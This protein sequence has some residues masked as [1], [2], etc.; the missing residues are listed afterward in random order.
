MALTRRAL[1]ASSVGLLAPHHI[2]SGPATL[3]GMHRFPKR[4]EL[5]PGTL[6]ERVR[7]LQL[8]TLSGEVGSS[9]QVPLDQFYVR[10]RPPKLP[11]RWPI[12][13]TGHVHQ[14]IDLDPW[15]FEGEDQGEVLME[16]SGNRRLT[17]FGLISTNR[18]EG[19][20]LRD[21]LAEIEL[22]PEAKGL[23]VIGFG[24]QGVEV[25]RS[26]IFPLE[27][28][29]QAFLATHLAGEALPLLHGAPAR[30][31]VP[32]WYGCCAIKWVRE[33]R[34]VG[35]DARPS[36]HM[37]AYASRVHQEI[38]N[39]ALAWQ[40]R[41]QATALATR[42]EHWTDGRRSW[43]QVHGLMW[44]AP[45]GVGLSIRTATEG[46]EWTPV[47]AYSQEST[48]RTWR[49][50]TH[51]WEPRGRGWRQLDLRI[52]GEVSQKYLDDHTYRRLIQV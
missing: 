37:Y 32:G 4:G 27:V 28:L 23:E 11:E 39:Q 14:Q 20:R 44:G 30:L 33:L 2:G 43:R 34:F 42:V 48:E 47:D 15:A 17:S 9:P 10:T 22:T 49:L 3:L 21:L 16:C 7:P 8:Q 36:P 46:V 38:T 19:V 35:A 25:D 50:W 31:I 24:G 13:V 6:H 5:F 29:D 51:R 52:E 40:G 45:A 1:L 18:W 26:W 41:Q 12:R